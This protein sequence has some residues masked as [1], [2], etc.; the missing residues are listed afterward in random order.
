MTTILKEM[1]IALLGSEKWTDFRTNIRYAL[2]RFC[3]SNYY[4]SDGVI[5]KEFLQNFGI[6]CHFIIALY[7]RYQY[8]LDNECVYNYSKSELLFCEKNIVQSLFAKKV[9]NLEHIQDKLEMPSHLPMV[10]KLGQNSMQ[11]TLN[12]YSRDV[13]PDFDRNRSKTFSF[14]RPCSQTGWKHFALFR[15]K[16]GRVLKMRMEQSTGYRIQLPFDIGRYAIFNK[17]S[18]IQIM[19]P[20][21]ALQTL[22]IGE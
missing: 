13:P 14:K 12:N 11:R 5:S 8:I 9:N 15:A 16:N 1:R 3:D 7:C 10:S 19:L 6:Y 4:C 17:R 21:C 22:K 2:E 20:L 18:A